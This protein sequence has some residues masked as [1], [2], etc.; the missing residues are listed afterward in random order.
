M[1]STPP[2][3][4]AASTSVCA[5]IL[6]VAVARADDVADVRVGDHAREPI[7]AE[8][9]DVTVAQLLPQEVH[10]DRRLHAERADDDV[11]VRE[12]LRLRGR[13]PRWLEVVV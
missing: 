3:R 1:L 5:A 8:Q 12:R 10:L 11:L 13:E 9:H 4:F 7:A 2:A 6:E